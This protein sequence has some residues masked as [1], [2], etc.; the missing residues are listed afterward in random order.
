M[1]FDLSTY[2]QIEPAK[3]RLLI[4]EPFLLDNFFKRTVILLCEHNEE[5]SFGFVLNKYVELNLQDLVEGFP[6]F[7]SRISV[8]G[9]V[10]G[11]NVFYLHTH[12]DAIEGSTEVLD[13]VYVGGNFELLK[14]LIESGQ[15]NE[16]EVR[17]FIGYSGWEA[18]QLH[19]EMEDNSWIVANTNRE[20][21][22]NTSD[23]ELW[24]SILKN[25]GKKY[26]MLTNFPED[27]TLN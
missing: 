21:I 25:M 11:N 4:S 10:Q 18:D 23:E 12:G 6:A 13:G 7:S 1:N 8:G 24:K 2:N 3:G 20:E 9:P 26:E 17:F 16:S 27:P 5:G 19:G 22:M 15:I 14:L